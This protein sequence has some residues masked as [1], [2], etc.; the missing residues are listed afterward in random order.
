VKYELGK[1]QSN[2]DGGQNNTHV[3]EKFVESILQDQEP[4]VSGEEGMKSLEVILAALQ[5][6]ETKQIV[7]VSE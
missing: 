1:I 6:N 7:K 2:D 5:S 4:P 3:I